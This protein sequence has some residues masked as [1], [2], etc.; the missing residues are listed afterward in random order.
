MPTRL[1]G[2]RRSSAGRSMTRESTSF[3]QF[4]AVRLP[5]VLVGAALVGMTA[6]Y[7]PTGGFLGLPICGLLF[8]ASQLTAWRLSRSRMVRYSLRAIVATVITI[9]IGFPNEPLPQWYMRPEYTK[10]IG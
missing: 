5:W 7:F 10:L 9:V 2:R 4:E 3:E 8:V 6:H 1:A